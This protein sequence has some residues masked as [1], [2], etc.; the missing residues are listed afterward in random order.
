[1]KL[2]L[3]VWNTLIEGHC[4]MGF[5]QQAKSPVKRLWFLL[6]CG[7][8]RQHHKWDFTGWKARRSTFASERNKLKV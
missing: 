7:H 1:M 4:R 5:I 6:K 8:M 2:D 3:V